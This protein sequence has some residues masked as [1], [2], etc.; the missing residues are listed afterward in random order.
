MSGARI[1]SALKEA[2]AGNFA[3]I[4]VDGQTW[5]RVDAFRAA[6]KALR[7]YADPES[8]VAVLIVGDPPCG[9]FVEDQSDT[10]KPYGWRHGMRAREALAKLEPG[11]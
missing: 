6:E 11:A 10:G 3:R 1:I 9:E 7:F 4:T 8:Y 5:V 2:V